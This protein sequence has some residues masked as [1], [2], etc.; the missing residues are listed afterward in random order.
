[1]YMTNESIQKLVSVLK[2]PAHMSL[3]RCPLIDIAQEQSFPFCSQLFAQFIVMIKVST[4][5][6]ECFGCLITAAKVFENSNCTESKLSSLLDKED[7]KPSFDKKAWYGT[8]Q[9]S[10]TIYG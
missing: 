8:Q 6:L 4:D 2:R 10:S 9:K 7:R 1:K 3:P 5:L